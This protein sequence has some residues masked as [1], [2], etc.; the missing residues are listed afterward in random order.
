M[1]DH[2]WNDIKGKIG[3]WRDPEKFEDPEDVPADAVIDAAI[4]FV[5]QQLEWKCGAPTSVVPYGGSIAFEFHHDERVVQIIDI[6]EEG[7]W[8]TLFVDGKVV[9]TLKSPFVVSDAELMDEKVRLRKVLE[10]LHAIQNGP[11]LEKYEAEWNAAMD[12]AAKLLGL[13][14]NHG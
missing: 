3:T 12:E 9:N 5:D 11:P 7:F 8:Q 2:E 13:E 4:K 14:D 10:D 6:G 1:T